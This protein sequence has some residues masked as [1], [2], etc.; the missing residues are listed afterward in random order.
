MCEKDERKMRKHRVF[1]LLAVL[2]AIGLMLSGCAA[3]EDSPDSEK[4]K[5]TATLF[6]QYDFAKAIG[7]EMAEVNLLLPPGAE[8]HSF[9]PTPA[10]II[11]AGKSD[12]FIYTGEFMEAWAKTI[13]ESLPEEVYVLDVSRGIDLESHE[14]HDG[15]HDDEH[16]HNVDPHVWTNP[17]LAMQ[18][19]ENIY[20]AFC[21]EDPENA[22][23]YEE[24]YNAVILKLKELDSRFRQAVDESEE[25]FIVFGGRFAFGYFVEEYGI[26]Y[27]SAYESCSEE[28]EPSAAKISQIIEIVKE[29]DVPVVFYEELSA[30]KVADI[31]CE[32]TGAEKLVLHSCHNISAEDFK[33]GVTYFD[34]MDKNAENLKKGLK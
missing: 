30:G 12:I 16:G 23:Y 20:D 22:G 34:L 11:S 31:I 29:R 13:T 15:D 19:A 26:D 28:A 21:E 17:V 10:D 5:I 25:K 3:K 33:K 1:G 9:E 7:G 32:E 18:M 14:D 2:A 4:I 24:N 27:V 6:P 8:S